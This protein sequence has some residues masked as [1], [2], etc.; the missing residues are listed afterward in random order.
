MPEPALARP[1]FSNEDFGLIR[2]ALADAIRATEDPERSR[3][4]ANLH[5]R[6]GRFAR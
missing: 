4:L 1:V 2:E 5:H 6:M 3:K